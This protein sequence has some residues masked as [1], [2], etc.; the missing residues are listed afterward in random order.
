MALPSVMLCRGLDIGTC[1][2]SPVAIVPLGWDKSSRGE[3]ISAISASEREQELARGT[4][5]CH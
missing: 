4:N 5:Q 3:L 2:P 1:L